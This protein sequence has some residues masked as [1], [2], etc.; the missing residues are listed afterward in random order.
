[1]NSN[2]LLSSGKA[3]A[4]LCTIVLSFV[5]LST[6]TV[7]ESQTTVLTGSEGRSISLSDARALTTNFRAANPVS[8]VL[9]EYFGRTLVQSVLNQAGADGLR[10]YYGRKSDG[11]PVLVLVGVNA[12]GQD[13]TGGPLIEGGWPCPPT[14]AST[15]TLS[16]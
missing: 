7:V 8:A 5:Y 9:G 10:I 15:R 3:I 11:T 2:N 14:C 16:R 6:S 13:L 12:G 4:F 1:M